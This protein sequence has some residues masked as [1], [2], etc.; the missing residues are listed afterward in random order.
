MR[1]DQS[2]RSGFAAGGMARSQEGRAYRQHSTPSV[3]GRLVLTPGRNREH[4]LCRAHRAGYFAGR[5][6][7]DIIA[8]DIGTRRW[9]VNHLTE[10][11]AHYI[12]LMRRRSHAAPTPAEVTGIWQLL[13]AEAMELRE[14]ER[15]Q[16]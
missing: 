2:G 4:E 9:I 7:E 16:P 14:L 8:D 15:V 6:Y 5:W 11:H 10:L 12:D 13:M 1:H 3:V